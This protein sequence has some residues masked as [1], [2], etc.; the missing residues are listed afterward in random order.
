VA[1]AIRA[2]EPKA[3]A[4]PRGHEGEFTLQVISYDR[5]EP[6]RAFAEGLR[7]KG[8][9]AFVVTAEVPSRGRYYRVRVGPFKSR[10]EAETYRRKFED[11]EH[12]N[13]FVV[14]D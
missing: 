12:M 11:Q 3:G 9:P 1:A 10:A 7:A 14:R 5:P 8:H 4:A 13:T 2:D 6:S